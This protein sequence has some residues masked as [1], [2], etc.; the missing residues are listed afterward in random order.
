MDVSDIARM[1]ADQVDS[2]VRQLLPNAVREGHEWRVGSCA[3][4]RGRS[5]A[6]HCH[7]P[8]A[9]IWK[10][11]SSDDLS[12]DALDLVAHV[13]FAGDKKRAVAWA[14]SWLGI[15][16]MDP[17]R[18]KTEQAKIKARAAADERKAAQALVN[19]RKMIKAIWLA[20]KA[21]LIGTPVDLYLMGRG[22][23]LGDLPRL[24]G[25]IRYA[26]ALEHRDQKTG[27][28]TTWP[29]M[30]AAVV[31]GQGEMIS[32]HRTYLKDHG[33]GLVTK[34]PVR[35]PKLTLGSYAGGIIPLA[36]GASGRA[37]KDAPEGDTIMLSEGIEDG[38]TM[39][40]CC[41]DMR[42]SAAVTA[43]N[44]CDV[45]LPPAIS[46]IIIARQNKDA[47]GSKAELS[48]RKAID[49]FIDQGRTVREAFPQPGH[50]DFNAWLQA[51]GA[52]SAKR[53]EA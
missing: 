6:I 44:M 20:A 49:R 23:G 1:L 25:A 39:A 13:L 45:D 4:E 17:D 32:I 16:G 28:I 27:E 33:G 53:G 3:G 7:A 34:A 46:T 24:P 8:R 2:L 37:I 42:C 40:L 51:Q 15:D 12:G 26:P 5:M 35:E 11:F 29:A 48:I 41:P 21:G 50:D 36:R 9:G 19:K 43:G 31:D 30:V 18:L 38:L 14:K 22:I 47:P 10:D 52:V